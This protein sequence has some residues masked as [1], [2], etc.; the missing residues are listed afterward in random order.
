M[1]RRG[2][3]APVGTTLRLGAVHYGALVLGMTSAMA[4]CLAEWGWELG[5]KPAR[6]MNHH[7]R[8]THSSDRISERR[9]AVRSN[10]NAPLP[11]IATGIENLENHV[12]WEVFD[13]TRDKASIPEIGY[14]GVCS[15]FHNMAS[16]AHRMTRSA[17]RMAEF[18]VYS[19]LPLNH[20]D[21]IVAKTDA[22][23]DNLE[24]TMEASDWNIPILTKRGCYFG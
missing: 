2:V 22:M 24:A 5:S 8:S 3:L 14:P 16:P 18:L 1:D 6:S 12:H 20:I 19:A 11:S 9:D 4:G 17:K 15:W 23:R 10:S 21:C 7:A 13:E